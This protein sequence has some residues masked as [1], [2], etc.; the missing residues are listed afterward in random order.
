MSNDGSLNNGNPQRNR[1]QF[2]LLIITQETNGSFMPQ[3]LITC[4]H[5]LN[6]D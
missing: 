1:S 5:I 6:D 2:I 4:T 3:S